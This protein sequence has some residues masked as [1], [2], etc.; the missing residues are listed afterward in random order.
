MWPQDALKTTNP[1]SATR[2]ACSL[3]YPR[4]IAGLPPGMPWN[5]TTTGHGPALAGAY[6]S[7]TSGV[8]SGLVDS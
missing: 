8:S 7:S 1:S 5:M 2:R 4:S 6:T 3:R